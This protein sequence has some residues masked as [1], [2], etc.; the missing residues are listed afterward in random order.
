MALP[1]HILVYE[2]ESVSGLLGGDY[3][4]EKWGTTD[5]VSSGPTLEKFKFWRGGQMRLTAHVT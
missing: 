5:V 3:A 2:C 1:I 4:S